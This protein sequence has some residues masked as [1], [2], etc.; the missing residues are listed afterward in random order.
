MEKVRFQSAGQRIDGTLVT[1]SQ[2]RNQAPGVV[3]F[4][5]M[6]S[7][8]KNYIPIAERLA[9]KGIVGM[10]LSIRGHGSSEGEFDTLTVNDAVADGL[11]AYDFFSRY[12]FIDKKR[13]GLCGAS[14]GAA[15]AALVSAECDVQSLVLRVPATYTEKMM[16]MTYK[17]IMSDEGQI[18][19][20]ITNISDTPAL[21]AINQFRGNL[22]IVTSEH[23]AVIPVTIPTHYLLSAK[24][25]VK[26]KMIEISNAT[27][28]LAKD[29]WRQQFIEETVKWFIETL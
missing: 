3:F 7:S 8:E 12:D 10:T 14:V 18:F 21:R 25:T 4:H 27:H 19:Q 15:V 26:K 9:A 5:G 1:P 20:K 17:Q 29:E 2:L 22:M 28:N 6:T 13:I 11:A 23:D 16:R 24:N